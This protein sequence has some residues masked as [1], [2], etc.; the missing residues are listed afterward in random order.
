MNQEKVQ[1]ERATSYTRN[2][3]TTLA[4]HSAKADILSSSIFP[5]EDGIKHVGKSIQNVS[6]SLWK[7]KVKVKDSTAEV[8][9]T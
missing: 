4:Q 8:R 1:L 9:N 2:S 3:L 6:M 7:G 5:Q